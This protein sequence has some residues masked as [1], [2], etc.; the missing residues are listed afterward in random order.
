MKRTVLLIL[1]SLLAVLPLAAQDRLAE[2]EELLREAPV[3]EKIVCR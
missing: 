1:M 2:I 3:Q